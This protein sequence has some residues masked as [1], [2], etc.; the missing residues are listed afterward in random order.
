[1]KHNHNQHNVEGLNWKKKKTRIDP[2]L[3][4][5]LGQGEHDNFI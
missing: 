4:V 2:S 1:M 3:L 5:K